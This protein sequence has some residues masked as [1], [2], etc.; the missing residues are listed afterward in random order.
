MSKSIGQCV[1]V[2]SA[3]DWLI[4]LL[5]NNA[6]CLEK[7]RMCFQKHFFSH[8][9]RFTLNYFS[10]SFQITNAG[11]LISVS[12]NRERSQMGHRAWKLLIKWSERE[13]GR[14]NTSVFSR[15]ELCR[16]EDIFVQSVYNPIRLSS[17]LHK[18]LSVSGQ[19]KH[20]L[21]HNTSART[22]K[23]PQFDS[24]RHGVCLGV[25]FL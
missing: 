13:E 24:T 12:C 14:E 21:S 7:G 23:Y 5:I 15:I 22:K 20:H 25:K 4:M 3:R 9:D 16:I 1:K 10:L 19:I 17:R 6:R 11:N 18:P 2:W 8:Y